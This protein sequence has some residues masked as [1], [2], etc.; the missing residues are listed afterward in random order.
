MDPQRT[1]SSRCYICGRTLEECRAYLRSILDVNID[2]YIKDVK[3][4]NP[5]NYSRIRNKS[6]ARLSD[7]AQSVSYDIFGNKYQLSNKKRLD[8]VER[9]NPSIRTE[10]YEGIESVKMDEVWH[11]SVVVSVCSVCKQLIR[12]LSHS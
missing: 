8:K 2:Q 10:L 3:A 1:D 6:A 7:E 12:D 4:G 5:L 11:G 9:Y